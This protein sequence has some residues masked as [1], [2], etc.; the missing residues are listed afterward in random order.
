MKDKKVTLYYANWCGHCQNFKP[1]WDALKKFFDEHGVKHAEFEESKHK[2][3][4]QKAAIKAYPTIKITSNGV[5]E[6][7]HGGM[8]P[9]DIISAVLPNV[10]LGGS[11]DSYRKYLKY[12]HK[13]M[14]LKKNLHKK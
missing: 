10:Q 12:K 7:Y 14:A 1:T 8:S 6:E 2:F 4:M 3:E 11:Y 13:Y 9:N 5:E